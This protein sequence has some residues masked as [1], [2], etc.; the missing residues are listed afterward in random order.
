M[1]LM[2]KK[3][4]DIPIIIVAGLWCIIKERHSG[5][6]PEETLSKVVKRE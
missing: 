2:E 5:D 6:D 1:D 4:I 3:N